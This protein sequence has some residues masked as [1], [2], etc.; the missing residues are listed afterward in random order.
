MLPHEMGAFFA[1]IF[2][3]LAFLWLALMFIGGR[4]CL[5]DISDDLGARLNQLVYPPANAEVKV[6]AVIGAIEQANARLD[7]A[8][9]LAGA[10]EELAAKSEAIDQ[11]VA[12]EVAALADA[13]EKTAAQADA[14]SATLRRESAEME[15]AAGKAEDLMGAAGEVLAREAKGLALAA[16]KAA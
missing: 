3:P 5:D 15:T 10:A 1:G 12:R 6:N 8:A 9:A 13:A 4:S 14:L 11:V 16:N 7:A 2:A